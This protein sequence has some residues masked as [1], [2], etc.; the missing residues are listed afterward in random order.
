MGCCLKIINLIKLRLLFSLGLAIIIFIAIIDFF[1]FFFF[2]G[3]MVIHVDVSSLY[4]EV[5]I[6]RGREI[7]NHIIS[8]RCSIYGYT[9][10]IYIYIYIY[11]FNGGREYHI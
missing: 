11:I 6:N 4:S 3:W 7:S 8:S 2:F 5:F 10:Q 1:F 9:V